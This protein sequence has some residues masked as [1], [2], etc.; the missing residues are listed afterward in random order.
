LRG[1]SLFFGRPKKSNQKKGRPYLRTLRVP[2]S[3]H[4]IRALLNSLHPGTQD[5]RQFLKGKF[6][7]VISRILALKHASACLPNK[8]PC[9]G[10]AQGEF[11][12]NWRICYYV[13]IYHTRIIM[14]LYGS[15]RALLENSISAILSAIE[16]YNK[17]RISY[18][19]ECFVILLLNSWELIIKSI[20]SK[21]K[22]R[23][24]YEKK[25]NEPYKTL[26]LKDS[27][28]KS[29]LLYTSPSPRD[30]A[31]LV[32]RLLLAKYKSIH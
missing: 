4:F 10:A 12:I 20:L 11:I 24:F 21:N 19:A 23:I 32:C 14:N 27:L 30:M 28:I 9:L 26:N 15:Y 6:E 5:F 8:A 18:R 17:P 1:E 22:I 2:E 25:R 16:I 7:F 31:N 3:Q 29:C 13:Q